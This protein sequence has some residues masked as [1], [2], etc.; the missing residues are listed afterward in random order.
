MLIIVFILNW[1]VDFEPRDSI[2]K[3]KTAGC[4]EDLEGEKE[5]QV[6]S[7]L[8]KVL[9]IGKVEKTRNWVN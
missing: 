8:R 1:V 7:S 3:M 4:E 9:V 2:S 6:R 5:V